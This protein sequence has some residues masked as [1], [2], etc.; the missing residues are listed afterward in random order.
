VA[1]GLDDFIAVSIIVLTSATVCMSD[2]C[3]ML[4]YIS[5]AIISILDVWFLDSLVY[6]VET[7]EW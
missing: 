3:P 2:C 6:Y 5:I 1:D 7:E 4:P